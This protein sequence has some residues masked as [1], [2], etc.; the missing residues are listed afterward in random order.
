MPSGTY[1]EP[2]VLAL[3]IDGEYRGEV[4]PSELGA[5]VEYWTP[6]DGQRHHVV[7]T[8]GPSKKDVVRDDT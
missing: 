7:A 6:P 1:G 5:T 2:W 4:P 8:F 3:Y